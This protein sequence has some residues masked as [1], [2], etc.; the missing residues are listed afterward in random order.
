MNMTPMTM[1]RSIVMRS[2]RAVQDYFND[3]LTVPEILT[4]IQAYFA[5]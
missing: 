2:L 4:L 3:D 5:N 1:D